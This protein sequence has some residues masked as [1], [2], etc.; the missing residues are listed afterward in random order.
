[1]SNTTQIFDQ[2]DDGSNGVGNIGTILLPC[3]FVLLGFLLTCV[4]PKLD[5]CRR[6]RH[7]PINENSNENLSEEEISKS[8]IVKVRLRV[9][10]QP[11]AVETAEVV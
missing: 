5:I 2:S 7:R 11:E 3:G 1:M 8:V 10:L 6:S 9:R 4:I